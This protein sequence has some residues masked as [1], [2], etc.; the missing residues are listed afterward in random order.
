MTD[1]N[2]N[3]RVRETEQAGDDVRGYAGRFSRLSGLTGI[4]GIRSSAEPLAGTSDER[5]ARALRLAC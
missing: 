2:K 3:D 1:G 5:L 4:Q